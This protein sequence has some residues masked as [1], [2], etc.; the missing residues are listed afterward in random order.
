MRTHQYSVAADSAGLAPGGSPALFPAE[1]FHQ[2]LRDERRRVDR[3]G[4]S[5]ALVV[6][7]LGARGGAEQAGRSLALRIR[8]KMRSVDTIGWLDA[9]RIAV[10]LPTTRLR[11]SLALAMQA[12]EAF[13]RVHWYPGGWD[14]RYGYLGERGT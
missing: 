1:T 3:Q 4:G 8:R 14:W 5:F 12:P 7:H 11:E 9:T 2:L 13:E 10:L 6:W